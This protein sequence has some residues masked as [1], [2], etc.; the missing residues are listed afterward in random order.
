MQSLTICKVFKTVKYCVFFQYLP[1]F[2]LF[3]LYLS[4]SAFENERSA[5]GFSTY[6]IQND[7]Y[8]MSLLPI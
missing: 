5:F 6:F 2:N 7:C 1:L 8:I 4:L 3:I